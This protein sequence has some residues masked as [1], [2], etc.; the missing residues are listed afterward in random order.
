MFV[1]MYVALCDMFVCMYVA[2]YL[3]PPTLLYLL[4]LNFLQLR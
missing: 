1:C 3:I 4:D 2:F